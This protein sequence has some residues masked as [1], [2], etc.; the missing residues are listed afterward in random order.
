MDFT[1]LSVIGRIALGWFSNA[2]SGLVGFG[3]LFYW[4]DG[5]TSSGFFVDLLGR[6][7]NEWTIAKVFQ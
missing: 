1:G 7:E 2:R 6:E 3:A 5:I 4:K